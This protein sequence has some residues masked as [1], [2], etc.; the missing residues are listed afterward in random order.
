MSLAQ[1]IYENDGAT[2]DSIILGPLSAEHVRDFC[3]ATAWLRG[4]A[5]QEIRFSEDA[6]CL[7]DR[8]QAPIRKTITWHVAPTTLTTGLL[9]PNATIDDPLTTLAML[10][11]L[12]PQHAV[13]QLGQRFVTIPSPHAAIADYVDTIV[14][15]FG[16]MLGCDTLH[17]RALRIRTVRH[18]V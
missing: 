18:G 16:I 17:F 14:W 4:A 13:S 7:Y 5:V 9:S 10:T 11:V 8:N 2:L 3:N 6:I 15:E 1:I 12:D